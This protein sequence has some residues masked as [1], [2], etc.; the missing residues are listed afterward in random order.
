MVKEQSTTTVSGD[1]SLMGATVEAA[2]TLCELQYDVYYFSNERG[3][4]FNPAGT[5]LYLA[6][7]DIPTSITHLNQKVDELF[8]LSSGHK[9]NCRFYVQARSYNAPRMLGNG[10]QAGEVRLMEETAEGALV[11]QIMIFPS[12]HAA[13]EAFTKA[14][15]Y[16]EEHTDT[17]DI[18][19]DTP[20]VI[21]SHTSTT[22]FEH[23]EPDTLRALGI[24]HLGLQTLQRRL[25]SIGI[26]SHQHH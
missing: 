5:Q 21:R 8:V 19:N 11:H 7:P 2:L 14:L 17:H 23:L 24:P 10:L 16:R 22:S 18:Y 3:F 12:E 4:Y 9:D 26:D 25:R 6:Y 15:A 1:N 20:Y 13:K